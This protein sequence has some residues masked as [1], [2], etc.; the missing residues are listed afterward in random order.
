MHMRSL[1]L[2]I[3]SLLFFQIGLFGQGSQVEFGKNRVQYHRDFDEWSKYES[4]NFITYWYGEGRNVGQSVVQLA[5]HDFF[6]IQNILEHR[7]NQKI[8]IIVYTDL[9]DLKQSNI[10]NEETFINTGGQT[11]IVGNK[12]FVFFDGNHNHL[13]KSIREGIASVYLDAMLFGSNLQEIVQNAVMMNLPDWFKKGLVS[14]V[15]EPWNTEADNQLRDILL[16]EKFEGFDVF[17]EENP[18]LAGKSLWYF[19]SETFGTSTVSNL[20]YL[21]RIN[22]SVE[23]GFHY[24]LGNSY[25]KVISSWTNY[26]Q[27]RYKG[28]VKERDEFT[29]QAVQFKNKRNLPINQ[30]KLSVDGNKL[31]YVTNEIGKYKVYLHDLVKNERS[32]LFKGGFRNAFQATDYNYPLIAWSPS[33]LEISIVYEKRDKIYL[34]R[35]DLMTKKN[36]EE[37]LA[38]QYQRVF[39]MEYVNPGML[40]FSA[41]VQGYS[42]ILL[43]IPETRQSQRITRDFYDD[44]DATVVNV[45]N[46]Q[47]ILFASNRPDSLL[48]ELRLDSILP[49]NT[50]DLFYYDLKEKSQELVRVTHTP[51]ANERYPVA[52]DTT[53]F[54]YLSDRSGI[55]N[56]E[57]AYLKE[58]IHHYEQ[59]ISLKG[60]EEIILHVDSTLAGL[61]STAIDTI[62]IQPVIKKK[63]II[64]QNSNFNR[65]ILSQNSAPRVNKFANLVLKDGKHQIFIENIDTSYMPR[66]PFS[67]YQMMKLK[68]IANNNNGKEFRRTRERP[69]KKNKVDDVF[70]IVIESQ[71]DTIPKETTDKIKLEPIVVE[72]KKDSAKVDIDNYLFQSE[73]DD[74]EDEKKVA[75]EN[76]KEA[77]LINEEKEQIVNVIPVTEEKKAPKEQTNTESDVY[78]FRPGR[79]TPYRLEF[80]TDYVI[81][82]L[83]NSLLFGGL[84]S[85]AANPQEFGYPPPGILLKANFKDL[86]EDYQFEGGLRVPTTFNGTE[87]FL[88]FDDK[89]QRLDKRY[90]VYRKNERINQESN[91]FVPKKQEVN[92]VLGQFSVRYPLDIF[93]SLR[94]TATL[95]RDRITQ[96][97]TEIATL[98]TP[99]T[100]EERAG[101]KLEY[102]FDNTLDVALNL[103]NGSR[104]KIYAEAIKKFDLNISDGVKLSLDEGFMTILG[105]DAR[106]YQRVLKHSVFA[107]R[108]AAATS[109]GSEQILYYLGGVDNWLFPAFNNETPVA[110]DRDFSFESLSTNLRGFKV[111]IRNGNSYALINSELRVP[112]FRYLSRRVRSSF[113]RNFQAVGFFDLGTAWTGKD[114]Y[115]QDNP[116]NTKIIPNSDLVTVKVNFFRDP[117]VAGYGLGVRS[118][119]F[120]YFIRLDYAWG[121]ETRKVQKPLLYIS[122][123]MDF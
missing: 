66:L 59:V 33:G 29:Q 86:F 45:E 115:G 60:G 71:K 123:G 98:E 101:L 82:Q 12:V 99:T 22:R 1:I 34:I 53:Y 116:L 88:V 14:Y 81:T 7:I 68:N 50:F 75:Q 47:G 120:G 110:S 11:K 117:M 38:P 119:L 15:G 62:I 104:Y 28:E 46:R 40:V 5:E 79:I 109:F 54:A 102:V 87:Y 107:T 96:L 57:M 112:I 80:R 51:F 94:A 37:E 90:A 16:N 23:S 70:Q 77:P 8:Q 122:L 92:I 41:A 108:F 91:S 17:A 55:Y 39:S 89:K 19:I 2:A 10:G 106:H 26:F 36:R 18:E 44:L 3:F 48:A 93:R 72:E 9:T 49:I 121:I 85:Y 73:F 97:A 76:E 35:H 31:V 111:N 69:K 103:K 95:R 74:D 43:Y 114:P 61:D 65:S 105:V 100:S 4:D 118:M 63:A 30:V 78:K 32:L 21:T 6:D 83:D 113:F 67:F 13:R 64:H 27:Q 25:E 56:R 20:L 84:E 58:Y 24:V 42:D 52:V